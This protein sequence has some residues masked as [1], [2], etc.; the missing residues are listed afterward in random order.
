V[1]RRPAELGRLHLYCQSVRVGVKHIY[2]IHH[3]Y[4][5]ADVPPTPCKTTRKRR[6]W[7]TF[8]TNAINIDN[9]RHLVAFSK[10]LCCAF[11][12]WRENIRSSHHSLATPPI[13]ADDRIVQLDFMGTAPCDNDQIWDKVIHRRRIERG[14]SGLLQLTDKTVAIRFE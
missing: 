11:D 1:H 8:E 14:N 13:K 9:K 4:P 12:T 5:V 7:L 6:Q 3:G 2:P 10:V